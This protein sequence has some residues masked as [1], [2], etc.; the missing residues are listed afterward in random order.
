MQ[1]GVCRRFVLDTYERE[2]ERFGGVDAMAAVETLFAA[3]SQA[4]VDLLELEHTKKITLDRMHLALLTVDALLDG[5]GLDP[6]ARFR[7][8][9]DRVRSRQEAGL[10]YRQ[11]KQ[12]LRVLLGNAGGLLL[13]PRGRDI[14]GILGRLRQGGA[15]L[16]AALH[17]IDAR[18]DL[19][20]PPHELR[21]SI[22][23]LHLNR[24]LGGERAAEARVLG[25]L[26]RVREG[27][28]RS[29]FP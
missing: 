13:E 8:C 20:R 19:T 9:R 15:T 24:L 2:I 3:D 23:H 12:R 16:D 26:W 21:D 14:A 6:E 22:V 25:L 28:Q 18:A 17:D 27:L 1:D 7:W 11:S 29:G 5:L 4:V 10:E